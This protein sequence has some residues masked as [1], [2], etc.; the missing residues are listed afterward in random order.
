M[1]AASCRK[2]CFFTGKLRYHKQRELFGRQ[3]GRPSQIPD[4]IKT[5]KTERKSVYAQQPDRRKPDI[6]TTD[7]EAKACLSQ[8]DAFEGTLIT[9]NEKRQQRSQFMIA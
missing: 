8:L 6:A 4:V 3:R 5:G 9:L 1:A 7:E 2:L